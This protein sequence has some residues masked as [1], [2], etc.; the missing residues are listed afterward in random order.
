MQIENMEKKYVL[1]L[2]VGS[3]AGDKA[4]TSVTL[5]ERPFVFCFLTHQIVDDGNAPNELVQHGNYSIDWSIQN[6]TRFWQGETAPMAD[7]AYG[8]VRSGE[9]IPFNKPIGLEQKTTLY[10][11]I[12]NRRQT[13]HE[14]TVQVIL[15]GMEKVG[16]ENVG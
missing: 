16:R 4:E 5:R 7:A 9:W 13:A 1:E 12:Q 14:Y 8:S 3:Q 11:A 10:V 15:H 6:D 2:T